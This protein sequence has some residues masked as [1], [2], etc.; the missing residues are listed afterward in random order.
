MTLAALV[1]LLGTLL[2]ASLVLTACH[3]LLIARHRHLGNERLF[4]RQLVMLALTFTGLIAV[5]FALPVQNDTRN[6]VLGL[7]GLLVSG[8]LAFSST[9]VVANLFAGLLLRVTRP[10]GTGDYVRVGNQFGRVA[11]RG[12][13]DTEIQ[14]Q[15]RELIALPNLFLISNPI[16]TT[17]KSGTIISAELS[18]GYDVHHRRVE[19][20]LLQAAQRAGLEDPFMH[21]TE[22][23]DFA[24]TY[25]ISGKLAEVKW[26]LT[27]QSELNRAVLDV[28]HEDGIEIASPT[29][30]NQRRAEPD[31]TF[32]PESAPRLRAAS[33]AM[34]EDVA[35]DKAEAADRIESAA[36]TLAEDVARLEKAIADAEGEQRDSLRESLARRREQLARLREQ[37]AG[38]GD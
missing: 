22:L 36:A 2:G 27:S 16:C 25:R 23:G 10:F 31:Q 8:V 35:F 5:I 30:M 19:P 24:V 3:L 9:T 14:S 38:G 34:A 13:F 18:L 6:Q 15:N 21:V 32:L 7:I 20:L 28:L 12:L 37:A 29:I 17:L 11:E 26:R 1:P 33:G 4:P